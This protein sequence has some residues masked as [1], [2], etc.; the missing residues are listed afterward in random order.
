MTTPSKQLADLI[1]NRLAAEGLIRPDDQHKLLAKLADG[2]LRA[3]DWR[4]AV[5]P[6]SQGVGRS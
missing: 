5:E 6:S 3:E 4:F 2:K 1:L